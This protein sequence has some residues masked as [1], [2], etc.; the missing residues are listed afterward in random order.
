MCGDSSDSMG[1]EGAEGSGRERFF[2]E[3]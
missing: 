2:L 1:R 3:N